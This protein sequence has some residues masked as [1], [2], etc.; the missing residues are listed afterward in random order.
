VWYY[1]E[2]AGGEAPAAAMEVMKMV[3]ENRLPISLCSKAD[4]SD[5]VDLKG[6]SHLRHAT[7]DGVM[8][9]VREKTVGGKYLG[10]VRPDRTYLL[11]APPPKDSMPPQIV[12]AMEKMV[13]PRPPRHIGVIADTYFAWNAGGG[14]PSLAETGQAIPFFGML[15]GMACIGHSVCVFPG[16]EDSLVSCCKGTDLVIVDKAQIPSLSADWKMVL[17]AAMRSRN[18]VVHD[19]TSF[20][21]TPQ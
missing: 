8:E 19:Q 13:P 1:R 4:F 17:G 16:T 12:Q 15:L 6:V 5:Y 21:L 10:I 2:A 9:E 11:I 18:I 7:W 20:K 14:V 3:A